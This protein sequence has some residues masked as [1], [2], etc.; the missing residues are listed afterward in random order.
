VT[1]F[2]ANIKMLPP[3]PKIKQSKEANFGLIFRQFDEKNSLP[4]GDYEL[5][6]TQGD[7]IPF[8]CVEDKQIASA[9]KTQSKEGNL[10]RI[11]KGTPGAADYRKLKEDPAYFVILFEGKGFCFITVNNFLHIKDTSKRKSLTWVEAKSIAERVV[12]IKKTL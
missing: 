5:K 6:Q 1:L 10:V 11:E 8:S 12:L 7:S 4:R 9:L 2:R 3:L